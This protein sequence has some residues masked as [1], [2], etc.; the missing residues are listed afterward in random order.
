MLRMVAYT[1]T[2]TG[3]TG[4]TGREVVQR[5]LTRGWD[6]R[7]AARRPPHAGTWV[8]FDWNDETTWEP[9]FAGSDAAY[10]LIPFNDPAAA[11]LTPRLLEAAAAA[12]ARRIALLTSWDVQHASPDNLLCV[13][14]ATLAAL[15]VDSAFLRP[16]WFL[17][18][19]TTGSF[20]GMTADGEMRLPAGDGA[21]PFIDVRDI[22]AVAVEALAMDGPVGPLTL[23]GPERI[24]HHHV[25]AALTKAL[26]RPVRYVAVP[27]D[28][29]IELI[30][31]RGFSREYGQFLAAALDD[32]ARGRISIEPT[33]TV[34]R[35]LGRP[36]Y[37]AAE[38]AD[39]YVAQLAK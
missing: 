28:E 27:P 21:I 38:F 12:G 4:K 9:A 35:I 17:D 10:V 18:N 8:P 26:G 22:A 33:E 20:A 37:S 5:A 39:H 19:F 14:E 31:A 25:A 34:E 36:P 23:T 1:V 11:D 30:M 13:T 6:V 7:A 2:V 29:F 15:P 16:T 32:V 3:P 24:D